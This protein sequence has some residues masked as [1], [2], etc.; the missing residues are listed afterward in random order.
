MQ[1]FRERGN[2]AF[3]GSSKNLVCT[4][5]DVDNG[6]KYKQSLIVSNSL[7]AVGSAVFSQIRTQL[8]HWLLYM[9]I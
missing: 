9:S 5:L 3:Q 2:K 8:D 6:R 1:H 4:E 7:D